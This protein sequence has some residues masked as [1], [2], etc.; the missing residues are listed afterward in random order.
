[1]TDFSKID[2]NTVYDYWNSQPCNIRHSPRE[3]GSKEY[4]DYVEARKYFVEP[5]IP[6]FTEFKNWEE[7]KV[8][9]IGYGIGTDTI[10]FARAGVQVTAIEYSEESLKIAK[11]RA[12]VYNSPTKFY[13]A[14]R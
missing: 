6:G 5:N 10:N 8:L 13:H 9:E 12:K 1:M 14:N 4:L 3:I 7:K 2:I 11:E